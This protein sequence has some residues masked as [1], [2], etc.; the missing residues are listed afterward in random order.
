ME[1]KDFCEKVKAALEK[2]LEEGAVVRISE[3]PKN[4]G[5]T[6]H[7]VSIYRTDVNITPTIYLE[8]CYKRYE[9][10]ETFANIMRLIKNALEKNRLENSFDVTEYVDLEKAK[11]RFAFKLV[12]IPKN[13][14]LLEE[15]PYIPYLDMAIVFY[16]LLDEEQIDGHATIT[17]RNSH[18][19]MWGITAEDLFSYALTNA[20]K[21]LPPAIR[22][23]EDLM[24]EILYRQNYPMQH[25]HNPWNP[26]W[27]GEL[28]MDE[29]LRDMIHHGGRAPMYILTNRSRRYGAGCILYPGLLKQIGQEIHSN[30]YVLP[31]SVHET[32]L[33]P[34][35]GLENP[36]VLL[37][38]VKEVN[39]SE[40]PEEEVLSDSVY[41]YDIK[42][43]HLGIVEKEAYAVW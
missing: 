33:L 26:E 20:G 22:N 3:V 34:D 2:D 9:D 36:E 21:L 31:S 35:L 23:M 29:L 8:E 14:K 19:K 37:E 11:S 6:L 38:M 12:N 28:S 4:N 18:M 17:I 27:P 10:G 15:V 5:I 41:Y 30:F 1:M 43:D 16:Y 42:K 25:K 40:V 32:I 13:H 24:R 7:G 39:E